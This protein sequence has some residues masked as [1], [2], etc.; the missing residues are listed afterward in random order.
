MT[1]SLWLLSQKTSC[2]TALLT[3]WMLILRNLFLLFQQ[4]KSKPYKYKSTTVS[5]N[6]TLKPFAEYCRPAQAGL[7]E[8]TLIVLMDYFSMLITFY[9]LLI[10]KPV[11]PQ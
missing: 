11:R 8:M 9:S 4:L 5:V 1:G 6:A 7:G 2:Q 10:W 3:G